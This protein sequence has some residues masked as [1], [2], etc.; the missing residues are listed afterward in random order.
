MKFLYTLLFVLICNIFSMQSFA[1][2]ED[3]PITQDTRIKTYVYNPSEVYLLLLHFGYQSHVEFA[4]G[5]SVQ[6]ISLGET[7]AWKITPLGNRLFIR[8]LEK[9]IKTNMT[10][11]TNK[12]TYQFDLVAKELED[13]EEEELVYQIKFFY[14]KKI[15]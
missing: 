15:K 12:R 9:N 6:T 13:G 8:P 3:L 2:E 10:V 7:F 11:I 4:S 1:F 5:E 14:P